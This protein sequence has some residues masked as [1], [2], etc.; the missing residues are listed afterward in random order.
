MTKQVEF[1]FDFASPTAY[2][3]YTQLPKIAEK[4][5]AKIVYR[6]FLLGGVFKT[7]GN[8]TPMTVPQKAVWM[9]KDMERFAKRYDVP[10]KFNPYFPLNT[11]EIMRGAV[12][13]QEIGKLQP[14][15]DA[16]Y[17]AVWVDERNMGNSTEIL[18]VVE[19]IPMDPKEF[20]KA[21][22]NQDIK[23]KLRANTDEAFERG[24][25]GAP[26]FFVGDQMFFG[27]DRLDFVEEALRK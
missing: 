11:I 23:D 18:N 14:Y 16:M 13:A 20:A 24:A 6:P 2:L 17:K 27:Q 10:L 12:W 25:F 7:S 5:G 15:V 19:A 8:T 26:T 4:A 9:A 22:S 21:I 1:F 3:A